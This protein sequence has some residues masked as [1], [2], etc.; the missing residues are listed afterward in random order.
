ML[1]PAMLILLQEEYIHCQYSSDSSDFHY[2][3]VRKLNL[4][5]DQ[6]Q[7]VPI[8]IVQYFNDMI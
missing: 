7:I 4:V 1:K 8:K 6:Y 3:A 2:R 5:I